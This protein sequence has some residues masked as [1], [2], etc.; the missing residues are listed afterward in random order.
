MLVPDV[1]IA[2]NHG[3]NEQEIRNAVEICKLY[4]EEFIMD[5]NRRFDNEEVNNGKN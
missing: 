2:Y 5:W 4:R 1:E 3:L